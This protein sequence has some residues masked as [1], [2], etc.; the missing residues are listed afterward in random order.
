[1]QIF[2]HQGIA[3][4]FLA[5]SQGG[6]LTSSET[7]QCISLKVTPQPLRLRGKDCPG[8]QDEVAGGAGAHAS[9][10]GSLCN[11]GQVQGMQDRRRQL[12]ADVSSVGRILERGLT[13]AEDMG[14]A[15]P[16]AEQE[17]MTPGQ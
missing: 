17:Y 11:V 8:C 6:G 10:L 3:Q 7:I 5:H 2:H 4:A 1:M 16:S 12:S 14:L 9:L 15:W 13:G